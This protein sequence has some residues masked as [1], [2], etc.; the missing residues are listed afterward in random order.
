MKTYRYRGHS[1]SDPAKYRT[2]EEVDAMRKQHDPI[3]QMRE[4]LKNQNITDEQLKSIDSDVKV[5]VT[6]ATEFAQTSP[7][8]D[9]AELFTDI[10]LPVDD[11]GQPAKV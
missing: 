5:T 11:G 8:P 7:E 9:V 10:L 6:K 4:V 3:D 2:R 1:M